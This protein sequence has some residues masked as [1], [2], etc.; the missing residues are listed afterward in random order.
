MCHQ[1]CILTL[2]QLVCFF[3]FPSER[4]EWQ[5]QGHPGETKSKGQ[6]FCRKCTPETNNVLLSMRFSSET[7]SRSTY[8]PSASRLNLR[9]L[10]CFFFPFLMRNINGRNKD[11]SGKTT[12][13]DNGFATNGAP[14]KPALLRRISMK[15][16]DV[17]AFST[18]AWITLASALTSS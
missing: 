8:V 10:V 5:K 3:P 11:G 1:H 9:Q 13:K 6:Q 12:R 16:K 4:H 2:R 15:P 7:S 14:L 17:H 18:T